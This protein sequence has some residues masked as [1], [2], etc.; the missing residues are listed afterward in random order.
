MNRRHLLSLIPAC[1]LRPAKQDAAFLAVQRRWDAWSTA[2][3]QELL[4]D[5]PVMG[6]YLGDDPWI[7]ADLKAYLRELKN[8]PPPT[9]IHLWYD[10]DLSKFRYTIRRP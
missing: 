6:T 3:M 10:Y 9:T 2:T 7:R 4:E 1:F 5:A 8:G